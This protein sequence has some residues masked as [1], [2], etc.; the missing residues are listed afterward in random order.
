ML[1][2]VFTI[3]KVIGWIVLILLLLILAVIALLLFVPVRYRAAGRRYQDMTADL[4]ASWLLR[5]FQAIV[6]YDSKREEDPLLYCVKIL[7]FTVFSNHKQKKD[8]PAQDSID[9]DK[10]PV[11][12]EEE[13]SSP[14]ES[15]P[16][17]E[18]AAGQTPPEDKPEEPSGHE[19]EAAQQETPKKQPKPKKKKQGPPVSEKINEKM[20]SLQEKAEYIRIKKDRVMQIIGNEKNQRWLSKVIMRLKRLIIILIP[21]IERL[22]LHFGF[23]DPSKTGKTLGML[24]LLYPVCEDR[25]VLEPEFDQSILEGDAAVKGHIRL[26]RMVLF[27]VPSFVNPQFFKLIKQIKKI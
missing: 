5:F 21:Q 6:S 27:A 7:G 9:A 1:A 4:H 23:S 14:E 26:I 10:P 20:K 12:P 13:V 11:L 24:S 22:Y 8:V 17:Q 19:Q 15:A 2:I 16:A 25:I 3:L 18:E